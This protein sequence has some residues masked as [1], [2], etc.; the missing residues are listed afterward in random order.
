MCTIHVDLRIY[1][2]SHVSGGLYEVE[3][4]GEAFGD[5]FLL[6]KKSIL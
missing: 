5:R 1:S 2:K 4:A 6:Y 3:Y